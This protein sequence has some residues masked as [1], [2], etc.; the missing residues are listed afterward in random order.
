M[1]RL[2]GILVCTVLKKYLMYQYII[3]CSF[4]SHIYCAASCFIKL[5]KV[6]VIVCG[7]CGSPECEDTINGKELQPKMI[8][9]QY[10]ST[11]FPFLYFT[12]YIESSNYMLMALHC[13]KAISFQCD[14]LR[15]VARVD[16]E[17]NCNG[18]NLHP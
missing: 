6:V 13:G 3:L 14:S 9:V 2:K 12:R 4:C 11:H 18:N 17:I 1:V 5:R 10:F 7:S 8:S 15:I 16:C